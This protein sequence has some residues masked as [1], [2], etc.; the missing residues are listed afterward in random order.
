MTY[1]VHLNRQARKEL[2]R[3]D[4]I[5]EQRIYD[6]LQEIAAAPHSARLANPLVT[7]PG[8]RYARVGAWRII[9]RINETEKKVEVLAIRSR[10]DVYDKLC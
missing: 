5:L 3:L 7:I 10:G 4:R 2:K 8:V 6:R 9:F 1:A